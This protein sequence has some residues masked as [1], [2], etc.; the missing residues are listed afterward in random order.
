MNLPGTSRQSVISWVR[1]KR[2]LVLYLLF[3]HGLIVLFIWEP[4]VIFRTKKFIRQTPSEMPEYR[5]HIVSHTTVI[6]SLPRDSVVFLGDSRMTSLDLTDMLDKTIVNFSIRGD[7]IP[8]L[9]TR[10]RYYKKLK[11]SHCVVIGVGVNDLSHNVDQDIISNFRDLLRDLKNQECRR[12]VVCAIFPIREELYEQALS[13]RVRGLSTTNERI[14]HINAE[15]K[16]ICNQ[17][18]NV[19]FID[20]TTP[21]TDPTGNL[22]SDLSS[23]GLHLND[24]GDTIYAES[25]RQILA[26]RLREL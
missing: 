17:I 26:M 11:D 5:G 1:K 14:R 18:S 3:L 21:L 25:L 8:G 10:I 9:R 19:M 2:I 15:W 4:L 16:A 6:R 7:T 24:F 23:D 22:K 12:I 13:A 20:A